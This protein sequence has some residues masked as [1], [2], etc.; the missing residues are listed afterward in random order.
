[1][2]P[3]RAELPP[4]EVPQ[5]HQ[6]QVEVTPEMPEEESAR[7]QEPEPVPPE[8]EQITQENLENAEDTFAN[9]RALAEAM[10]SITEGGLSEAAIKNILETN[11]RLLK[12]DLDP[13]EVARDILKIEQEII[14]PVKAQ[15]EQAL[16]TDE[17]AK[18]LAP[19][20]LNSLREGLYSVVLKGFLTYDK[21]RELNPGGFAFKLGAGEEFTA[22]TDPTKAYAYSGGYEGQ[23]TTYLYRN[24]LYFSHQD[25][26]DRATWRRQSHLVR[27]ELMHPLERSNL[28]AENDFNEYRAA[29]RTLDEASIVRV[30]QK[31]PE[32]GIVLRLLQQPE[33]LIYI[34][35]YIAGWVKELEKTPADESEKRAELREAIA[36][37]V[38][39]DTMAYFTES[40]PS[41][42]SFLENNFRFA[43]KKLLTY[44]KSSP[45]IDEATKN[46]L[47]T[48]KLSFEKMLG[49]LQKDPK[50][51]L[52][53]DANK[54]WHTKLTEAFRDQGKNISIY[55]NGEDDWDDDYGYYEF[56]FGE[57]PFE[58]SDE[59]TGWGYGRG[60]ASQ[61]QEKS[62]F[63]QVWDFLTGR[64]SQSAPNQGRP[65]TAFSPFA[66]GDGSGG[67]GAP[68]GNMLS[69]RIERSI[70]GKLGNLK[71]YEGEVKAD[72]EGPRTLESIMAYIG[73]DT[74]E[75]IK[76]AVINSE[77]AN[78]HDITK[79]EAAKLVMIEFD[80]MFNN[81]DNIEIW[82]GH[83]F[84]R[85]ARLTDHQVARL[86]QGYAKL[87]HESLRALSSGHGGREQE[88]VDQRMNQLM[89]GGSSSRSA[90][91]TPIRRQPTPRPA[92]ANDQPLDLAA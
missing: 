47:A 79:Q 33:N 68:D 25:L 21:I 7:A 65:E 82:E 76:Q 12:K 32:L 29:A 67:L 88:L 14:A 10:D 48:G 87:K 92:E 8:I 53:F 57:E 90:E 18:R 15:M 40:G 74:F 27:H 26:D 69:N 41:Q 91:P 42:I 64:R 75:R 84:V 71:Y 35:P 23:R 77:R 28:W 37:E 6:E 19:R 55:E 20:A 73:R 54:L 38:V 36:C 60:A 3:N 1:M 66:G 5:E 86:K 59:G 80:H 39:A 46:E 49:I 58:R 50:L 9:P 34:S 22:K 62:L 17:E 63:V 89:F 43:R 70:R 24:F 61:E 2:G 81:S 72:L 78:G 45:E 13:A 51:K 85:A 30:E 56:D 44:I 31:N 83:P 4:E 11:P 16:Q 52:L